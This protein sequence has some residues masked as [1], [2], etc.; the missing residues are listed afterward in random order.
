MT[1]LF[2]FIYVAGFVSVGWYVARLAF[3]QHTEHN[4]PE[5]L[6]ALMTG[7]VFGVIWPFTVVG[8]ALRYVWRHIPEQALYRLLGKGD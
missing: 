4:E 8:L 1:F 5:A 3:A 7:F 6:L 2:I